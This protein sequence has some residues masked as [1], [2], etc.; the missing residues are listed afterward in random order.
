M[1]VAHLPNRRRLL[2]HRRAR[3][4][5]LGM[6]VCV[7]LFA[8]AP[9]CSSRAQQDGAGLFLPDLQAEPH[10][11]YPGFVIYG[12]E[13][14]GE[15]L[16]DVQNRSESANQVTLE[17]MPSSGTDP[18]TLDRTVAPGSSTRFDLATEPSVLGGYYSGRLSGSES[19]GGSARIRWPSGV[20][21]VYVAAPAGRDFIL[22]LVAR[23]VYSHTSIVYAQNAYPGG[24]DNAIK[25]T[26]YDPANG[27]ILSSTICNAETGET[28]MWD[29]A[30]ARLDLVSRLSAP[31]RQPR[32]GSGRPGSRAA[33]LLQ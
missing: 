10:S 32:D 26:V 19:L 24:E 7:V 1:Y 12:Q 30:H 8:P 14:L 15:S 22:P 31:M 21:A 9:L 20:V 3:R 27:E 29:T 13:G 23:S 18:A 17:L 28:C 11:G 33:G 5:L 4:L 2:T 16:I 6:L 25:L